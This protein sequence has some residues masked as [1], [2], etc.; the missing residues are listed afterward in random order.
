[1]DNWRNLV[2]DMKE[3]YDKVKLL[4]EEALEAKDAPT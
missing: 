1:M 3:D 4:E 2:A